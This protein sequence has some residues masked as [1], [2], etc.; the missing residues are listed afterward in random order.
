VTSGKLHTFFERFFGDGSDVAAG[1]RRER[2]IAQLAAAIE[3]KW[4]AGQNELADTPERSTARL[5]A[6]LD[7]GLDETGKRDVDVRLSRSLETLE[8]MASAD[9][10]VAAVRVAQEKAPADLVA[11]A[12]ARGPMGT[13]PMVRPRRLGSFWKWSGAI[14]AMAAVAIAAIVIVGRL[15]IPT[16]STVPLIAVKDKQHSEKSLVPA[17]SGATVP[18]PGAQKPQM[19]PEGSEKAP[20]KTPPPE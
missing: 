6:Y 5:A 13:E 1:G 19:A 17:G 11:R 16:G 15:W 12:V 20:G 3:D 4:G 7:E 9:A 10:F 2:E 8:E 18:A 14:L